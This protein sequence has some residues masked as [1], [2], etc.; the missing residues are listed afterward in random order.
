M[1]DNGYEVVVICPKMRGFIAAEE[2]LE[3]IQIYRHWISEEAGGFVG[4]FREYASALWGEFRL[5]WKAWRLHRFKIIHLCN[6]PDLLF[7]VALPFKLI[8][9]KV[10]YDVHDV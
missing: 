1:R 6:P 4:F 3:S 5:A 2:N 7:L 8:G 9:V 10:I